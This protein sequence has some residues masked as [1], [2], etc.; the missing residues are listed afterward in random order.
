MGKKRKKDTTYRKAIN[1]AKAIIR[2]L[3]YILLAFGM[4]YA[5]KAAYSFGYQVCD[6]EPIAETE[7]E[8]QDV[9]VIIHEDESVYEI[10]KDLQEKG[11]IKDPLVF[12]AQELFS[13]YKDKIQP[14]TYLLNTHETVD[15]MLAILSR[16]NTEGQPEQEGSETDA[17]GE[18]KQ[19]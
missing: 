19:S 17:S 3:I 2:V 4:V 12:W 11:L 16:E 1:G 9:T 6:Q 14:G 10:G 13:D 18:E 8:G 15:E 5:G 7:E